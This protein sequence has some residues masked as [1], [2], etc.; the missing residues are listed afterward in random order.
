[1]H[2]GDVSLPLILH[3]TKKSMAD[4]A[5]RKDREVKLEAKRRADGSWHP[6]QVSLRAGALFVKLE[7]EDSEDIIVDVEDAL[8]CLRVRSVPLYQDDC[9]Y[10]EEGRKVLAARE[11]N[12]GRFFFDAVVEKV[13][14]VR[15]SKRARC[16]CSFLIKWL[17]QGGE[18]KTATVPSGSIMRLAAESISSHPVVTAFLSSAKNS[19]FCT[20]S[21]S[22]TVLDDVEVEIDLHGLLGKQIE[23]IG[24]LADASKNELLKDTL[25]GV[26][27]GI[28]A[29]IFFSYN[30]DCAGRGGH[31]KPVVSGKA[32]KLHVEINCGTNHVRRSGRKQ[33]TTS[34]KMED[35]I[36]SAP[37]SIEKSV[38]NMSTLNPLAARAVLASLVSKHPQKTEFVHSEGKKCVSVLDYTVEQD[39][40]LEIVGGVLM[41]GGSASGTFN[42]T[43][44]ASAELLDNEKAQK[45]NIEGARRKKFHAQK[46]CGQQVVVGG[47]KNEGL[48][49]ICGSMSS[50]MREEESTQPPR[51]SRLT[52]SA[53]RTEGVSSNGEVESGMVDEDMMFGRVTRS[54]FKRRSGNSSVEVKEA[55]H[56]N[57]VRVIRSTHTSIKRESKLL[58]GE[59]RSTID[60]QAKYKTSLTNAKR[61]TRSAAD[62][63]T[64]SLDYN[65]NEALEGE[66]R[67]ESVA[68]ANFLPD[69]SVLTSNR[70]SQL[71]NAK[72]EL[73]ENNKKQ[74]R[75]D[76]VEKSQKTAVEGQHSS[77]DHQSHNKLISSKDQPLRSSPRLRFLPRTQS[78]IKSK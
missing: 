65:V 26:N 8:T 64:V 54:A 62:A 9:C 52:R 43:V 29:M 44:A 22:P 48:T 70:V 38:D 55:L 61:V 49:E 42:Y 7:G 77:L 17:C 5:I 24:S 34:T 72:H 53:A 15:H 73:V 27:Y 56:D 14:K 16:R 19:I 45:S 18:T 10:I 39:A 57:P 32:S 1:M 50:S 78:Q 31:T 59:D 67:T 2:Y 6:C 30:S 11:Q 13:I 40:S 36:T 63:V 60:V 25:S 12:S 37:S 20:T 75:L 68:G 71:L 58:N 35:P 3:L 76:A 23:E 28:F 46:T 4:D 69:D 66:P 41:S 51:G 33:T 74:K 47:C 21:L